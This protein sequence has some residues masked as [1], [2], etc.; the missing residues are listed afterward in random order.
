MAGDLLGGDNGTARGGEIRGQRDGDVD[1]G[2]GDDTNGAVADYGDDMRARNGNGDLSDVGG[3]EDDSGGTASKD[4]VRA[5][6]DTDG[7]LTDDGDDVRGAD[8]EGALLLAPESG[9]D[10]ADGDGSDVCGTDCDDAVKGG[11]ADGG[12]APSDREGGFD[13]EGGAGTG[14]VS[15]GSSDDALEAENA[16][17]SPARARQ[18]CWRL[19]TKKGRCRWVI[20]GPLCDHLAVDVRLFTTALTVKSL[21]DL[22]PRE[23]YVRAV[24][25]LVKKGVYPSV[26]AAYESVLY[27]AADYE[28]PGSSA[29]E[30]SWTADPSG[31]LPVR[32]ILDR[33]RAAMVQSGG[34]V[35]RGYVKFVS[36]V[37]LPTH[38]WYA[39][40]VRLRSRRDERRGAVAYRRALSKL[41]DTDE[42]RLLRA[43]NSAA[44][45][46]VRHAT[47]YDVRSPAEKAR[48]LRPT[49]KRPWRG[50]G[51]PDVI[52]SRKRL[53]S[54]KRR[55]FERC[56]RVQHAL[57]TLDTD[58]HV[59]T[60]TY[61][62]GSGLTGVRLYEA[63]NGTVKRLA[64]HSHKQRKPER[65]ATT[66]ATRTS[67]N[68]GGPGDARQGPQ[69][70]AT[71]NG[72]PGDQVRPVR[73]GAGTRGTGTTTE[74]QHRASGNA[75]VE[76]SADLFSP[77]SMLGDQSRPRGPSDRTADGLTAEELTIL[78]CSTLENAD[79][80][81]P[82]VVVAVQFDPVS[83][84]AAAIARRTVRCTADE[85]LA[86]DTAW[87]LASDGGP[88]RRSSITLFT[89]TLSASW[90]F[91]GRTSMIPVMYILSGEHNMHSALGDRL[92]AL[93]RDAVNA[94]Y[95]VPLSSG[96][97]GGSGSDTDGGDATQ[98]QA[99]DNTGDDI[100]CDWSGPALLRVVGDFAM[101][102][103][104][105]GLTG[106]S[107]NSRCPFWWPCAAGDF[108]SLTAHVS[109]DGRP[110]TV[111]SVML[112]W[113]FVC[114]Q[115]ARWC[116]LRNASM[117]VAGGSV[118]VRCPACRTTTPL[119]AAVERRVPCRAPG[120]EGRSMPTLPA[121]S[122][123][124]LTDTLHKLRRRAGGVRGYPVLRSV[125]VVLQVPVLHCTGSLIKKIT[126]FFLAELG[127][128]SR[129][130]ARQGMYG[131][132]GR[133]TL[134][135]LYLR[136]HIKL[137]ALILACEEIVG[138]Q[139][140]SAILSM[141]SVAL[142]L[143]ASWRQALIGDV[144][145]R[146]QYVAVLELAAG[147]L[148]PMWSSL[149]PLDKE[150]KGTGV[151]SLYLHAALVHARASLA[152]TSSAQA[153][154]TDDH[155]E[156][157]IR[158]IGR[159]CGTR[160]NNV[161]RAQAVTEFQALAD[162]DVVSKPRS[163]FA[164]EVMVYTESVQI[165]TC[166]EGNLSAEQ[167]ADLDETVKRA[168]CSGVLTATAADTEEGTPLTLHVPA[169]LVYRP[170]SEASAT[171]S[172]QSKEERVATALKTQ[173]R[174]INVCI[175]GSAWGRGIGALGRRLA[176]LRSGDGESST[177]M[178][179]DAATLVGHFSRT[180]VP[181]RPLS[182]QSDRGVGGPQPLRPPR[183]PERQG[184]ERGR[185][186]PSRVLDENDARFWMHRHSTAC[187]ASTRV[188]DGTC[189]D[190]GDDDGDED[191]GA[192]DTLLARDE[193]S[194]EDADAVLL[195]RERRPETRHDC[196][197]GLSESEEAVPFL[198]SAALKDPVLHKYAPPAD[199]LKKMLCTDTEDTWHADVNS[200]AVRQRT[201]EE[202]A[203]LRLFLVRTQQ[204]AFISWAKAENVYVGGMRDAVNSVLR[205]L[206][207][208]RA[209]LPGSDAFTF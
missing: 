39:Y 79:G 207:D 25:T 154:V 70:P 24:P 16:N 130:V 51:A 179:A 164:A 3:G 107:D 13:D 127:E 118:Q 77:D 114:W 139:V 7:D 96:S 74:Q 117:S 75:D 85:V 53:I 108:L 182:P 199:L 102:A 142:L 78:R 1:A 120:C 150:S 126:H 175:C 83:A 128:G 180:P 132:T 88:V 184:R 109:S 81:A 8:T 141:W 48:G 170:D 92:D 138:V 163:G 173:M 33:A 58:G 121:V 171:K 196:P 106:G 43:G 98:R 41:T 193:D 44:L 38:P 157:A 21:P 9:D 63:P 95:E 135:Q 26:A 23:V 73:E 172:W 156:G 168:S 67:G 197:A 93:L 50:V 22:T 136:E 40:C 54:L 147:L 29:R 5:D 35:D 174:V 200:D 177:S 4:T 45:A 190:S 143:T 60:W 195:E 87:T 90:L 112:Q 100:V 191:A 205:K 99:D 69:E 194:E 169:S 28:D 148:A 198:A 37:P 47:T 137:A 165:C 76:G 62:R 61:V 113:E 49:K 36:F 122:P 209:S 86:A 204:P 129:A 161:A 124:P 101:L 72:V 189:E 56:S 159:H 105:M 140:D 152:D 206:H 42:R 202:D 68:V 57:L 71:E 27:V 145:N 188:C 2:A 162:D 34:R 208:M 30:P 201:S 104:I 149:K 110:R 19:P 134:R 185:A 59:V 97:H 133:S 6:D 65:V 203:M 46:A 82:E 80:T 144:S 17:V 178:P 125:R 158:E 84:M 146:A 91:G 187:L 52:P 94:S 14:D 12:D 31:P 15:L 64:S 166:V 10:G 160:V 89:L 32:R 55:V 115:L 18:L 181:E 192:M 155:A 66:P 131:V 20:A 123:T 103:H 11:C 176:A 153:I 116:T 151:T 186:G 111:H 183:Q 167:K 119:P